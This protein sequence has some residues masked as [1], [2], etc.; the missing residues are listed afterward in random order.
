MQFN[1]NIM[2]LARI[3][4][5][6]VQTCLL[7]IDHLDTQGMFHDSLTSFVDGNVLNQ[8]RE[9]NVELRQSQHGL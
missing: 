6:S 1:A 5:A 4:S 3:D 9:H 7:S 2:G 8:F